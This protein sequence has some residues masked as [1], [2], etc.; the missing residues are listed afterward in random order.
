MQALP[1][2]VKPQI[3][4][5]FFRQ[6]THTHVT[7]LTLRGSEPWRYH[8]PSKC[9]RRGATE[10]VPGYLLLP[11]HGHY[12]K[13]VFDFSVF[14]FIQDHLLGCLA[15]QASTGCSVNTTFLVCGHSIATGPKFAGALHMPST[16]NHWGVTKK[17]FW[18]PITDVVI[19]IPRIS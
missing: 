11:L 14:A 12:A 18:V 9:R 1:L 15:H 6:A 10:K 16:Q 4:W 7:K 8:Q 2:T 17:A 13:S 3:V 19:F 5:V